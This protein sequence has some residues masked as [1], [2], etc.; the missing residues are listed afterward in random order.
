LAIAANNIRVALFS[1][2]FSMFSFGAFSFLVPSVAFAQIGFV[3]NELAQRNGSWLGMGP[4]SPLQFLIGYVL[5]HG[6]IE[7][8]TAILGAALGLRIGAALLSPPPGFSVGQNMIWS[9]AQF[10]KVWALVLIPLFL[11]SGLIEGLIT[12]IVVRALYQ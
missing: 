10:F 9:L 4:Q 8:P 2:L 12:P 1:S 5:P 6:V 3:A 7:L 11:V